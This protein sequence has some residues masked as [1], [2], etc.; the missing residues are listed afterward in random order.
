VYG[1]GS[2]IYEAM[3][4]LRYLGFQEL[5]LVGVDLTFALPEHVRSVARDPSGIEARADDDP[6]HFDPRYFGSGRR[7]HKPD[8]Q[9]VDRIHAGLRYVAAV[10]ADH[11]FRVINAGYDSQVDCFE[12]REFMSCVGLTS[13]E[14][15]ALFTECLRGRTPFPS[16]A[17][18][19]SA[20]PLLSDPE[21]AVDCTG[22]FAIRVDWGTRILKRKILTHLP[23]GPF[24]DTLFFIQRET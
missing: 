7:Y 2:V 23:L 15:E 11:E 16:I 12:R 3:Q 14:V 18:L 9:V 1:G 22:S 21:R 8:A 20:V 4:I 17:A 13:T 19:R 24:E 5:V 6:N 10:M